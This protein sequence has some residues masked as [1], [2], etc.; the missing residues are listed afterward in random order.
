[1]K[2]Y[3]LTSQR[4]VRSDF[5]ANHPGLSHRRTVRMGDDRVYPADTRMAFIDWIDYLC[6]NQ[7]ISPRLADRVTL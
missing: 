4:Q 3:E 5:W 2:P 6:R 7:I 1:M